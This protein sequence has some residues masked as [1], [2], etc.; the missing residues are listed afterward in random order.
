M[1]EFQEETGEKESGYDHRQ[2]LK[3]KGA[4]FEADTNIVTMITPGSV[5]ELETDEQG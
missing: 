4:G 2:Y 3:V 1:L 5:T